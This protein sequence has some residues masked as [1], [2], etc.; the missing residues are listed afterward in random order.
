MK[1]K[2]IWYDLEGEKA[3]DIIDNAKDIDD[4]I[5]KGFIKYNGNPPAALYTTIV[6]G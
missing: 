5:S 3:T 2:I 6:M 4:A 1:V